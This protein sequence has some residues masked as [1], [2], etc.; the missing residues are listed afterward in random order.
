MRNFAEFE[1]EKLNLCPTQNDSSHLK[2]H[3]SQNWFCQIIPWGYMPI[4]PY[5]LHQQMS[6]EYYSMQPGGAIKLARF[7][8]LCA[9]TS[10]LP[11]FDLKKNVHKL[12]FYCC[13]RLILVIRIRF[14]VKT[15][16]SLI[17]HFYVIDL[18][19]LDFLVSCWSDRNWIV[20]CATWMLEW[21]Q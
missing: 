13:V 14:A 15:V 17:C 2:I 12:R 18:S 11:F 8:M 3:I 19:K 10:I 9:R 1:L 7:N 21:G 20:F 16:Y 4:W 6:H 5:N